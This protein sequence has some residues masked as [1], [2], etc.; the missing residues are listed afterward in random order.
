MNVKDELKFRKFLA[1]VAARSARMISYNEIADDAGIDVKAVHGWLSI[2][3]G[4]GMVRMLQPYGGNILK[5]ALKT[6][7]LFFMD[8]GLLCYLCGWKTPQTAEFGAQNGAIFETFAVSEIIKSH[9]N[10]K[11][12]ANGIYYYGKKDKNEVDVVIEDGV[13][14]YLVEMKKSGTIKGD[15]TKGFSR[16]S[17]VDGKTVRGCAV[18]CRC[19]NIIRIDELAYAVPIEAV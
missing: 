12:D 17:A 1:S 9:L 8:T 7:K 5:R 6:P 11:G 19:D 18:V 2:L 4:S 10:A 13:D 3:E 15:W 16:F 14:V